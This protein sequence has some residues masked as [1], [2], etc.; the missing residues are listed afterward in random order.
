MYSCSPA[1]L[2]C[3]FSTSSVC[4]LSVSHFPH[5]ECALHNLL[6]RSTSIWGSQLSS[7]YTG[8]PHSSHV[9]SVPTSKVIELSVASVHPRS[10]IRYQAYRL[11]RLCV[12]FVPSSLPHCVDHASN[13]RDNHFLFLPSP[14][15]ALHHQVYRCRSYYHRQYALHQLLIFLIS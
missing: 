10:N 11:L 5:S 6:D 1:W 13:L 15:S 3:L 9:P 4:I 12:K 8:T 2:L 7:Y 14:C